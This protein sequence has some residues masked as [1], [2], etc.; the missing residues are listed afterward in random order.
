MRQAFLFLFVMF[1]AVE[2][3]ACSMQVDENY[4]KNFLMAHAASFNELSLSNVSGVTVTDYDLSFST[5]E[6]LGACPDYMMASGRVSYNHSPTPTQH[7]S[8]AVTVTQTN[9]IGNA[10]PSGP[11]EDVTFTNAVASCST[12]TSGLRFPRKIPARIKKPIIVKPIPR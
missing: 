4:T 10:L 1:G 11:I 3:F 6:A 5:G 2:G 8:Y 7:C 12:S 9:Y